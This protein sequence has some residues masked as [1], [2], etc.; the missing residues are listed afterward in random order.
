MIQQQSF[1]F[2]LQA[3]CVNPG[4]TSFQ[5]GKAHRCS[6]TASGIKFHVALTFR[7]SFL[8]GESR[9]FK[10]R[11]T[12]CSDWFQP[13]L[14]RKSMRRQQQSRH[15]RLEPPFRVVSGRTWTKKRGKG[16]ELKEALKCFKESVGQ[17]GPEAEAESRRQHTAGDREAAISASSALVRKQ[18][19]KLAVGIRQSASCVPGSVTGIARRVAAMQPAR[20]DASGR[21]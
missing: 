2:A 12:N 3:L 16:Q 8:Y 9:S 10:T 20:Q 21:L 13:N 6:K 5:D 17:T 14:R 15:R 4:R 11:I 18:D 19:G 7:R 1:L